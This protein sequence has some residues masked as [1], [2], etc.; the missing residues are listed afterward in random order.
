MIQ[1]QRLEGFYWVAKLE[2]YARAA[3]AFPYP[4][5]QPGVHQQV[6]RLE[7]DLGVKLFERVGKDR[8]LLTPAG[9]TLYA[10]V[11]PFLEQLP[12]VARSLRTGTFPGTLR[13]DAAGLILRQLLPAWL[14]RLQSKR[15][16][17]EIVLT[18]VPNASLE[19]LRTGATDLLVDH[20]PSVPDDVQAQ[21]VGEVQSFLVLPSNHRLAGH[22]S[23]PLA[24]LAGEPFIA[25]HSDR[26][27]RDLQLQ[28]LARHGA[29]PGKIHAADSADT[30]LGFVAAGLGYSLVPSLSPNGPRMQGVVA[31]PL[32]IPGSRFPIFAAW[33]KKGPPNPFVEAAM[34]VAPEQES[35]RT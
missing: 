1:I 22:K 23:V 16:D 8:V 6:K 15:P 13:V 35:R 5:T 18:E 17:I 20:L 10:F 2:G 30:I 25:Y 26:L 24:S 9:R 14:R 19:R 34:R 3:R 32:K 12:E 31:L 33:R 21:H 28:V 11:A 29:A 7:S 4:I 27:L